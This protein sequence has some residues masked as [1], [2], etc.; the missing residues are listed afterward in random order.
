MSVLV[1]VCLSLPQKAK[2]IPPPEMVLTGK[3]GTQ[4]SNPPILAELG[5]RPA[6]PG[7]S[8][9]PSCPLCVHRQTHL[10]PCSKPNGKAENV[11]P[12]IF[13]EASSQS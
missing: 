1:A 5:K 9:L 4:Y 10:E 6:P 2:S 7:P 11:E 8:S 3:R 13:Y 12:V